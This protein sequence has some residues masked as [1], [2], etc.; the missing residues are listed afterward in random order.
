MIKVTDTLRSENIMKSLQRLSAPTSA[1]VIG[2]LF[3]IIAISTIITLS[4]S[5]L[6]FALIIP[7]SIIGSALFED[8]HISVNFIKNNRGKILLEDITE[9]KKLLFWRIVTDKYGDSM[10]ITYSFLKREDQAKLNQWLKL[11]ESEPVVL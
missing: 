4:P 2:A 3:I 5:I 8:Y 10:W 6:F 9:L 11:T 7:A 1:K